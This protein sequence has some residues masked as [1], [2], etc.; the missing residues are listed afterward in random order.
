MSSHHK[1]NLCM[2]VTCP[3]Q[4]FSC[5][6]GLSGAAKIFMNKVSL[7]KCIL[8]L[9][10]SF[11]SWISNDHESEMWS[12]FTLFC[13]FFFSRFLFTFK[14]LLFY[15]ER[16]VDI[17]YKSLFSE[18][19]VPPYKKRKHQSPR[20]IRKYNLKALDN[21]CTLR[22]IHCTRY[23][24]VPPSSPLQ[25]TPSVPPLPYVWV[26]LPS[27]KLRMGFVFTSAWQLNFQSVP[28]AQRPDWSV[29]YHHLRLAAP[30]MS[31]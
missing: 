4:A 24:E 10:S 7:S 29:F 6:N 27:L 17:I 12:F 21:R 19:V 16:Q 25:H 31:S 20:Y 2:Y 3:T 5:E 26:A 15:I 13:F 14:Q 28:A 30:Q 11:L 9:C 23:I 1:T 22:Y 8:M 18:P